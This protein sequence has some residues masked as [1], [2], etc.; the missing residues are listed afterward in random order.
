MLNTVSEALNDIA[1]GKMV[2]VV[3]DE[4]RE[5][6]GD[7]IMAASMVNQDAVNFM[8][9][10]GRGLICVPLHRK[11][12]EKFCLDPMVS[13]NTEIMR[14]NFTV[15]VDLM[16]ETTTGISMSDRAKTI[17]ALSDISRL[18][19]DFLRPGH[20]F[21]IIAKDGGVKERAGHTEAAVELATLAGLP[22]VGVLCEIIL[23]NGQMARMED[24]KKF[25]VL[26]DLKII[27]IADLLKFV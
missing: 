6:E 26:H 3:D 2:V 5:N 1:D 21:P 13:D 12:A 15:S 8:A 20:V 24:L 19:E 11:Y 18:P 23:N 9:T 4:N 17:N 10:Y 7:L 14:T 27:S 22:P 25:S 16:G